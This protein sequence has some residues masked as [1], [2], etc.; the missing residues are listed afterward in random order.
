M[1][2]KTIAYIV[3]V[4]FVL[5]R[6]PVFI[7]CL[8]FSRFMSL[9]PFS[10]VILC[11]FGWFF[12]AYRTAWVSVCL[13]ACVRV[14]R[15]WYFW[16][17]DAVASVIFEFFWCRRFGEH[18]LFYSLLFFF[19]SGLYLVTRAHI[20]GTEHIQPSTYYAY[21]F[22]ACACVYAFA[23][24]PHFQF[25]LKTL[26]FNHHYLARR[27]TSRVKYLLDLIGISPSL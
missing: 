9:P 6:A 16:V 13:C 17:F 23:N 25:Y 12:L 26:F 15:V 3:R 4:S 24:V 20:N 10:L 7:C 2:C 22:G 21:R 27:L 18:C 1:H 8:T 11:S 5:A 19:P 14:R